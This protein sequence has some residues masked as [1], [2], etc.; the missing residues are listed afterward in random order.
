[1]REPLVRLLEE[2]EPSILNQQ[3][4]VNGQRP[5]TWARVPIGTERRTL[6][7]DVAQEELCFCLVGGSDHSGCGHLIRFPSSDQLLERLR[8]RIAKEAEADSA[9]AASILLPASDETMATRP[10]ALVQFYSTCTLPSLVADYHA[11]LAAARGNV[12]P[13]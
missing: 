11:Y 9:F 10:P 5:G 2:I 12:V 13:R 7:P 3:Q 1:M 4:L 8:S 6:F